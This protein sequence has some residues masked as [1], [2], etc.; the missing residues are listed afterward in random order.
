MGQPCLSVLAS[1]ASPNNDRAADA[2]A[3]VASHE[4]TEA[5]TDPLLNAWWGAGGEIGDL[6][7]NWY[8]PALTFGNNTW[9][10]GKANQMWD[11][12]FFELQTEYDNHTSSCV[13]V[14]P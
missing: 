14:G 9:D 3:S 8:S 7:L 13:Q 12:S 11:G 5:I 2:A 6:C 10:G 1:R 4:L